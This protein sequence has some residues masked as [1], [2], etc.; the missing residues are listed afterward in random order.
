[1]IV[2]IKINGMEYDVFYL[3]CLGVCKKKK[4][5]ERNVVMLLLYHSHFIK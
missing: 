4:G 3:V 5:M 2:Y 1:M